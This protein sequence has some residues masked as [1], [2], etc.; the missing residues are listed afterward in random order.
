MIAFPDMLLRPQGSVG[1]DRGQRTSEFG[2]GVRYRS[3]CSMDEPENLRGCSKS[4]RP[5]HGAAAAD[6]PAE[7]KWAAVCSTS[8]LCCYTRSR[9]FHGS[10]GARAPVVAAGRARRDGRT[11]SDSEGSKRQPVRRRCLREPAMAKSMVG[12]RTHQLRQP[13]ERSAD[14]GSTRRARLQQMYGSLSDHAM[15]RCGRACIRSSNRLR[16]ARRFRR[17]GTTR[18][19]C[20]PF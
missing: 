12:E 19:S 2:L 18:G 16:A 20:G 13:H 10:G 6:L 3:R 17:N 8:A 15:P 5:R 7:W 9:E 11:P 14:F 1:A 4:L